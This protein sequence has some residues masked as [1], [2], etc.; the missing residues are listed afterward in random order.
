M[1]E[2][3]QRFKFQGRK[4]LNGFLSGALT[5]FAETHLDARENFDCVAAVPLEPG[6]RRERGF[7]QSEL[8]ARGVARRF[9]VPDVSARLARRGGAAAQSTLGKALRRENVSGR[10]RALD[11]AAFAGRR[12]LLVDDILTTGET[13]SECARVLKESGAASVTVLACA[14][15]A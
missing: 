13:A 10:F 8:L 5:R 3:L 14:R 12:V 2:A 4:A 9:G 6:R 11:P 15:G 7:N 1:R